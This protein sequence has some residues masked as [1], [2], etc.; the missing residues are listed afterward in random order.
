MPSAWAAVLVALAALAADVK[1]APGTCEALRCFNTIPTACCPAQF[2]DNARV[3]VPLD[4]MMTTPLEEMQ[5]G[6]LYATCSSNCTSIIF[7]TT[8]SFPNFVES[9]LT[10]QG[11]FPMSLKQVYQSS[12][13]LCN[14]Y[15]AVFAYYTSP[16]QGPSFA[17]SEIPDICAKAITG[18]EREC[19]PD[20]RAVLQKVEDSEC[21]G[22]LAQV[23]TF[24]LGARIAQAYETCDISFAEDP[25]QSDVYLLRNSAVGSKVLVGLV[26]A[27]PAVLFA[28]LLLA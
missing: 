7:G 27:V 14:A 20:C 8:P 12:P 21:R 24:G 15:C 11:L 3:G 23:A 25:P 13:S 22:R 28:V 17:L 2:V 26:A 9:C 10:T 1:A 5:V 19:S 18:A 6:A 16:D 4:Q